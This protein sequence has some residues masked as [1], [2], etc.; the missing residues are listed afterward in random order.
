MAVSPSRSNYTDFH[1]FTIPVLSISFLRRGSEVRC[2]I[3][4]SQTFPKRQN[5]E[6][7]FE[8]HMVL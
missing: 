8:R 4:Q 2:D 3:P 5:L 1:Y 6:K 7:H